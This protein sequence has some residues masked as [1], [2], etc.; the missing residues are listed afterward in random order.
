MKNKEYI[1]FDLDGTIT[2]SK[3]GILT[4]V[5]YAMD[6][7]GIK[8]EDEERLNMFIGPPLIDAFTTY[9]GVD[10]E[11]GQKL[12]SKY[13]EFYKD[14]GIYMFRVYDGVPEMIK[15]IKKAGK[16]V[17]LATAKPIVFAER[18]IEKIGIT[19]YFDGLYGASMD[20]S[21]N[22]K[23]QVIAYVIEKEQLEKEKILMVG[24]RDNDV[25]G[26]NINGIDVL[27]VLY[28]YGTKKEL[29][30]AGCKNF[31]KTVKETETI[32]LE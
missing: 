22:K 30:E 24:D 5:K 4:A 2:D 9:D 10:E 15:K 16:K 7:Y 27:G 29:E 3:E 12:V 21:R 31:A 20:A 14:K 8:E 32:I 17:Y 26:A 11:Q 19:E 28:G 6:A 1:L 23:E 13:R 18:I 25:E